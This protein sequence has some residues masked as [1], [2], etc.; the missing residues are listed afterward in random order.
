VET[1]YDT[2]TTIVDQ[3]IERYSDAN[4]LTGRIRAATN[5]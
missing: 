4:D 2:V 1:V 3:F 5:P